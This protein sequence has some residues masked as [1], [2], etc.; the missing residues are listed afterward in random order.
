MSTLQNTWAGLCPPIQKW[1]GGLCPGG[2]LSYTPF[3]HHFFYIFIGLMVTTISLSIQVSSLFDS[4]VIHKYNNMSA[5]TTINILQFYGGVND[6]NIVERKN[7]GGDGWG[8]GDFE[9]NKSLFLF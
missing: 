8:D 1:V 2:I 3:K 5:V 7:R 9:G 4:Q 6:S